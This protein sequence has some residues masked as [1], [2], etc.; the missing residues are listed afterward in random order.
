MVGL[1]SA[2]WGG[3]PKARQ[4]HQQFSWRHQAF[5]VECTGVE[6]V[7]PIGNCRSYGD[8]CINDGG[9]VIDTL[10]MNH[11]IQFDSDS[12]ELMVEAGVLLSDIL[13]VFVPRGWFLPVTPGT[14]FVTVGGAI[15]NDVHGKNH[16]VAGTFGCFV[17]RFE[18]LRSDGA[19]LVCSPAE[20][21]DLFK[22]TIGGLGLTGIITWATIRLKPVNGAYIDQ[23]DIQYAHLK[24]FF[25]LCQEHEQ[26]YEYSVAWL[27]CLAQGDALGRGVLSLGNHSQRH[28]TENVSK[29][30]LSVPVS[31]PFSLVRPVTLKAFNALYYATHSSKSMTVHYDPYFYPLDKIENWNRIYGAKGFVQYQCAVPEA[32]AY[33]AI[34]EILSRIAAS[35]RGSFL[36]VLKKFGQAVSPGVLSFPVPGVT[37]ALDF[38]LADSG[39]FT[40]LDELDAVVAAAKGTIY[41]A[42][43][44]R[45]SAEKFQLFYPQW[46]VL[47][48]LRDLGI[49]S[50]FWRRVTGSVV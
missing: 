31:P 28:D 22:A 10:G 39:L 21:V 18:L 44:A 34:R 46:A 36:A 20:N 32:D 14:K 2:S 24:D 41:P 45:V 42:K 8:S 40:L 5:P 27:D 15:A 9:V 7:L 33:E 4:T 37:L 47:E 3:Y 13:D 29:R 19:R 25:D 50:S 6:G 16:H 38:P 49:S 48:T 11:F 30:K 17:E 26:G 23:R 43:D 12:G 1:S 35:G